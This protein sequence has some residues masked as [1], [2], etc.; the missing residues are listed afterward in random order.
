MKFNCLKQN[1]DKTEVVIFGKDASPW[2]STW[3]PTD[4]E[5]IHTASTQARNLRIIIDCKRDM[6]AQVNTVATACCH[7]L[8]LLKKIF[9]SLPNNTRKTVTQAL[10]T[11]RLDYRNTIYVGI[12]K[13]LTKR[14]QTFQNADLTSHHT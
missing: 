2:D 9:K 7:S 1:T 12:T 13:Q 11:S 4:L 8:R 3:W 14:L 10:I 6:S 5:P